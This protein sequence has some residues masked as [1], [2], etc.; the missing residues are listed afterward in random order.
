VHVPY[1]CNKA[2]IYG[3]ISGSVTGLKWGV[4][5]LRIPVVTYRAT[6]GV[7]CLQARWPVN[8]CVPG[9]QPQQ[10]K[11]LSRQAQFGKSYVLF[12]F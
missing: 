1:G 8:A 11:S 4:A 6:G 5:P 9:K 7:G 12:T 2:K 3:P 10:K